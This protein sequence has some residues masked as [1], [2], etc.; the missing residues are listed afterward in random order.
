MGHRAKN[1]DTPRTIN[2]TSKKHPTRRRIP[3]HLAA[4]VININKPQKKDVVSPLLE[5]PLNKSS[6]M[7]QPSSC[8]MG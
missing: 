7:L 8:K 2:L 4:A 6:R 5:E 1:E 3:K